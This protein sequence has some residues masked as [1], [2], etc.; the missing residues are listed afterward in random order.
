LSTV[1]GAD[2]KAN[3]SHLQIKQVSGTLFWV[4]FQPQWAFEEMK[5][6][7]GTSLHEIGLG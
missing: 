7:T 6:L 5:A 2:S 4:A 3:K 1:F